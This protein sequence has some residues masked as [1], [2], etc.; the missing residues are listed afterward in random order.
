[1]SNHSKSLNTFKIRRRPDTENHLQVVDAGVAVILKQ[2]KSVDNPDAPI[3]QIL[4]LPTKQYPA[5]NAKAKGYASILNRVRKNSY[6]FA[7]RRIYTHF[8]E[9]CKNILR[10]LYDTNPLLV[11]GKSP[12]VL[13]YHEIVKLGDYDSIADFMVEQ[14]FKHLKGER[15][16]AKTIKK[17]IAGT[18]VSIS[19]AILHEALGFFE[20]RHLIV[21]QG[22]RIDQT[23]C[24][25]YPD[26]LRVT[27]KAG[28]KL[29]LTIGF[30]LRGTKAVATLLES[31]DSQLVA[32]NALAK[33]SQ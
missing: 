21:H 17:L 12:G 2:I 33:F 25:R 14:V 27:T 11:V 23:F 30:A 3:N 20:V 15:S 19:D 5:L 10:E 24:D 4:G 32:S 29:P 16:T 9:Y 18:N 8:G 22:G 6:E 13:R 1:M 28:A 26:F 31:I 7:L